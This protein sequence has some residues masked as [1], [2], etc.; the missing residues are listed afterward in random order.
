[1]DDFHIYDRPLNPEEITFLYELR[2]GREQI[3]RLQAL[4]DSVGTVKVIN[5][6]WGYKELP[7]IEFS[8][9]MDANS[10]ADLPNDIPRGI[11]NH[12]DIKNDDSVKSWYV[13]YAGDRNSSW[14]SYGRAFAT[15]E[16][17]GTYVEKILWTK[18]TFQTNLLSL[19]NGRDIPR[20]YV[21]YVQTGNGSYPSPN[22]EFGA[23]IGLNGYTSPP[24]FEEVI[25]D[26][27]LTE[28][29]ARAYTLFFLDLNNSAQVISRGIG[30]D[31]NFST[32]V[33]DIVKNKRKRLS[34][35]EICSC[36]RIKISESISRYSS[37]FRNGELV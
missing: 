29:T 11:R 24:S 27:N 1:M 19:P 13:G 8:Y 12:G 21:E 16:L 20:R 6:G 37:H 31:D 18:D 25:S 22:Y 5:G 15:P 26:S 17:T 32:R 35:T 4:V 33:A 3:P 30:L 28:D 14:R 34:A 7:E 10:A 2:K 9:G 23:P 36:F